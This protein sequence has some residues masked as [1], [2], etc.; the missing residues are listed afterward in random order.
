[1]KKGTHIYDYQAQHA[2]SIVAVDSKIV[3][4]DDKNL[5][6]YNRQAFKYNTYLPLPFLAYS[7]EDGFTLGLGVSF[8]FHQFG[9][10]EYTNR[11]S[12]GGKV[13][14]EGNL[15]FKF[16]DELHHLI[17]KWDGVITG[18]IAQPYPFVYF[19]GFGN[20]SVKIDSLPKSY[21]RSRYNGL[22][23]TAGLR[24]VFWRKSSFSGRLF[25]ENN[26]GQIASD[27]LLASDTTILGNG[28]INSTGVIAT[29]NI[30]FRD[31][32]IIPKR[33]VRLFARGRYSYLT[34]LESDF[35]NSEVSLEFYQSTRTRIPVTL[36]LKGGASNASGDVP[37]YELNTVGRTTGLRG[38]QRDRFTGNTAVYFQS[39]L[40]V[41]FGSVQTFLA[42]LTIGIFGFFRCRT[43]LD[44]GG[45]IQ[46]IA[47]RIW[48]GIL[49]HTLI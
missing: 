29:L 10:E 13:S 8:T 46:H 44:A 18:E 11:L 38:Y 16:A 25:Y 42:P 5:V 17:G 33:G 3:F 9:E 1:V 24:K 6:E 7:P 48:W 30:D 31:N 37:F 12:V 47:Q 43:R 40:S 28:K 22:N 39:Q 14:T 4:S 27:N 34:N 49:P 23:L 15:E 2:D 36:G 32:P 19:Y 20:E 26:E 45:D 21:Y 35:T 41:E